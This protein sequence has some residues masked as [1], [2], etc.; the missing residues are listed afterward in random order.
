[1][2][3][4]ILALTVFLLVA[5]SAI[6]SG[7]NIALMS[8]NEGDL[9][10]KAKLDDPA[11]KR[12]LPLRQNSH[13]TLASI[14]LTNIG[15]IS[16]TSLVLGDAFSGVVAGIISTLLIVI[17]GEIFPQALFARHAL[18]AISA[19]AP[20]LRLMIIVTYPVSK[21]LQLLLDNLFG[22]QKNS[23][24][25]RRELGVI[26]TEHLGTH[27][28][29]LDEDEIEIMRSTLLLSTKRVQ[30]IMTPIHKVYSLRSTTLIDAGMIDE[31]KAKGWSRIP[32]FDSAKSRC[33]GVLLMKDLVDLDF[34]N[35]P[36]KVNQLPLRPTKLVGSMT[37]LDTLFR[38]F[39]NS[40]SH[41]MPVAK[42][43]SIVGIVTIEDLIEEILGHEIDDEKDVRPIGS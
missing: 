24:H 28:S 41:L 22:H 13:L 11:A 40:R 37:A 7:L 15:V 23:L 8:L 20:L 14:I 3:L 26:L 25:S 30:E 38:K 17:F 4:G 42:D 36:Q 6:C 29:E 27:E 1:M 2:E 5:F 21:P 12:A 31:I 39:I 35:H 34:D 32:I 43:G 18:R 10:R 9:A 19:F 33:H 16:A